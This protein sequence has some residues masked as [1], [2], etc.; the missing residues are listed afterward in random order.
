MRRLT[1]FWSVKQA[2]RFYHW[3]DLR[4]K[5]FG[6]WVHNGDL[7]FTCTEWER[8]NDKRNAQTQQA[9]DEAAEKNS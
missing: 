6:S 7:G 9:E 5:W 2:D 4:V 3:L 8:V 1:Y